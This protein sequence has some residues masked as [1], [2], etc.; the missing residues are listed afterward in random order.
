MIVEDLIH[1]LLT[2]S[3]NNE[4]DRFTDN[5][6]KVLENKKSIFYLYINEA[7]TKLYS[8][9]R[10]KVDELFLATTESRVDYPITS[11][12]FISPDNNNYWGP[13]DYD[14]YLWKN[15]YAPWEDNLIQILHVYDHHGKKMPMNDANNPF[16]VYTPEAHIVSIPIHPAGEYAEFYKFDYEK[17]LVEVIHPSNPLEE[18]IEKRTINMV[19]TVV[20]QCNHTKITSDQDK[21][22]LPQ[23]LQ[24]L[25]QSYVAYK[26]Y[27][28]MNTESAVSNA[29]KF[30][31][32]YQLGVQEITSE[33]LIQPENTLFNNKFRNRGFI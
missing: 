18:P 4:L 1:N 3:L 19:Y 25:L 23:H 2:G 31:Q 8:Q 10:L 30:L 17:N 24:G 12:H 6:F 5:N 26:I 14:H 28:N 33:S 20:Y 13:P 27:S 32:D 16:S 7:L 29:A 22:I 15:E 9:F 11:E 21:I